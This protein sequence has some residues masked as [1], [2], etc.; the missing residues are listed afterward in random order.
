MQKLMAVPLAD[1]IP[2]DSVFLTVGVR[3]ALALV[4]NNA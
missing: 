1:A 3:R 2:A 4:A